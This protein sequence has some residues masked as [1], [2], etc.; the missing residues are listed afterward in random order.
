MTG[1]NPG[2]GRRPD[3][4]AFIIAAVLAA[5]GVLLLWEGLRIPDKGGYSGV[6]PGDV[7][8]LIGFGL[9]GL[10]IW[11]AIDGFKGR[12][13]PRPKQELGPVVWIV[14][15]LALQLLL[16]KPMGF[17]VATG[18]LFACVA[19]AF[20]ERRIHLS[21]PVG[22][23]LAFVVYGVFDRLL[24]LNLPAGFPETLVYGG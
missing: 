19:Y 7:P 11:T 15:G 5:L 12:F 16:L 13:E 17:S 20:G 10:G 18:L 8:K 22:L 9:L 4:A 24:Q 6:G 21:L 23:V 14:G 2:T 3:G 1:Q